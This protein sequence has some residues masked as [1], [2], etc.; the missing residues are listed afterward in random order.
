MHW[1]VEEASV[2]SVQIKK[3]NLSIHRMPSS[4]NLDFRQRFWVSVKKVVISHDLRILII[5][6]II[7]G[8]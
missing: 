3:K 7:M 2:S 5:M 6:G 4:W 8:I 1:H